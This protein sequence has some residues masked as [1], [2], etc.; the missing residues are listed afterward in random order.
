MTKNFN[1]NFTGCYRKRF[2]LKK[3]KIL[4]KIF[5]FRN[6]KQFCKM[7]PLVV[8]ITPN[9]ILKLHDECLNRLQEGELYKLR[10]DAK[11]RAVNTTQS[12]DEFK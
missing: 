10:N 9:D 3:I 5:D 12:Y 11:L 7:D 6:K 4:H 1:I 8:K 2:Y